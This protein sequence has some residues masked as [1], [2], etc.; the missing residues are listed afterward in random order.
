[1]SVSKDC[2]RQDH[3]VRVFSQQSV[4]PFLRELKKGL[5]SEEKKTQKETHVH[6]SSKAEQ[7]YL[8]TGGASVDHGLGLLNILNKKTPKN[9][10][11]KLLSFLKIAKISGQ[12]FCSV[13][14]LCFRVPW[15]DDM[16]EE[17]NAQRER[18]HKTGVCNW[19]AWNVFPSD[20]QDALNRL[21]ISVLKVRL[22][23]LKEEINRPGC[24]RTTPPLVLAVAYACW[25]LLIRTQLMASP[26]SRFSFPDISS[27]TPM[28]NL[29]PL[30]TFPLRS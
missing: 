11:R 9:Y 25:S 4:C 24:T 6:H 30:H 12:G 5:S 29:I 18:V 2:Y 28:F 26:T 14:E 10:S 15:K 1:M 3:Q 20:C 7:Y 22:L 27:G 16:A 13:L 21:D 23:L 17:R 19:A 8:A